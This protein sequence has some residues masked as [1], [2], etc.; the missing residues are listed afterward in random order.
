MVLFPFEDTRSIIPGL[1]P[2]SVDQRILVPMPEQLELS[3]EG[4]ALQTPNASRTKSA[5]AMND[6]L[7]CSIRGYRIRYTYKTKLKLDRRLG[8]GFCGWDKFAIWIYIRYCT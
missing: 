4:N 8:V 1:G 2:V 6:R 3:C 7:A 5:D